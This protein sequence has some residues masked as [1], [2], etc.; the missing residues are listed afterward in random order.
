MAAVQAVHAEAPPTGTLTAVPTDGKSRGIQ[1]RSQTVDT[2]IQQTPDGLRAET[3]LWVKLNNPGKQAVVV[4][5]ALGGPQLGPRALPQILDVT[6]D[7]RPV[8]LVTLEPLTAKRSGG[9]IIAYTLPIT[10]PVKGSAALRVRYSQVLDE[11]DGLVTFTY[12]MTATARWSG[13]PE[14]LRMTLKFS[15]AAPADQVL[16]HAPAA[17]RYDRDGMTWNWDGQR[18]KAS[19]GA[20]FMSP[21]WWGELL[22]ARAAAAAPGAG[23]AEHLALS[24]LYRKL[25]ELPAPTFDSGADFYGRYFPS[26]VAELQ[27]ALAAP[28]QGTPAERA[29][30]HL[31]LAEIFLAH[32]ERLGEPAGDTYQQM[33]AMELETAVALDNTDAGLRTRAG[34]LYARVG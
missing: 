34:K 10:V 20:A 11:Q 28:A 2:T 5:M 18:P 32:A 17:G 27:A 4:P 15:P 26:E 6:L 24:R 7:N 21:T 29:V 9:P 12:P 13:T 30:V 31:R 8:A 1:L 16:S 22:T 3:V 33:A 14:S 23:L 25:S 19:I